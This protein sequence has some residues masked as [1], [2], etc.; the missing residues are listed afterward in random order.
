MK[1]GR[2]A[3][4]VLGALA[5]AAA[6]ALPVTAAETENDIED[7]LA[8][9]QV[10][11]THGYS[12]LALVSPN[13]DEAVPPGERRKGEAIV[14]VRHRGDSVVYLAPASMTADFLEGRPTV[15]SMQV[16][17]GAEGRIALEFKPSGGEGV[18]RS[19][20]ASPIVYAAGAYEGPIEYHGR[21]NFT[22]VEATRVLQRPQAL[23]N[24]LCSSVKIEE[25]G[26]SHVRGAKLM[27][28]AVS[29]PELEL[30]VNQNR[31]G[32]PV[33]IDTSLAEKSGRIFLLRRTVQTAPGDAFS[34]DRDLGHARLSPGTPFAGRAVFRRDAKRA[35]R[36]TGNLNV[37]L[38]GRA[39]VPVARHGLSVSLEHAVRRVTGHGPSDDRVAR[40]FERIAR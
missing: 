17:L 37:D 14:V 3:S 18:A 7:A 20:C 39:N 19:H 9:F 12:M 32:G 27:V 10:K 8:V 35:N 24:L 15:T 25:S 23:L 28:E 29:G 34:F 38:P 6:L 13:V 22:D 16:N 5:C 36:W 40:R 30:Q 26:G 31:P 21:Q 2:T 33:H 1:S 11:G 4:I